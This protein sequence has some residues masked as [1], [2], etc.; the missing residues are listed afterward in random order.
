MAPFPAG[1]KRTCSYTSYS[2]PYCW[3]G[4]TDTWKLH[5]LQM[6]YPWRN[7]RRFPRMSQKWWPEANPYTIH[8]T[9][10]VYSKF[11]RVQNRISHD[12][13]PI[14]WYAR[15]IT[16]YPKKYPSVSIKFLK[17]YTKNME[18][19]KKNT[20]MSKSPMRSPPL[21]TYDPFVSRR[22]V[23]WAIA[24]IMALVAVAQCHQA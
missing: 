9:I 4:W 18:K 8:Y 1:W 3:T 6:I 15:F 2:I 21:W 14:E 11:S 22:S 12:L 19:Q 23:L 5:H 20:K 10:T 16:V 7:L 24:Q 13:I 17:K